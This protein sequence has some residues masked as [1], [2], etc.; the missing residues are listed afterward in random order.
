MIITCS[1][2]TTDVIITASRI[3][4]KHAYYS[5]TNWH[6]M[7]CTCEVH[8]LVFTSREWKWKRSNRT[9]RTIHFNK[10]SE[11]IVAMQNHQELKRVRQEI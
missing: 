9:Q 8:K 6:A 7:E 1:R 2:A 4:H 11:N 10:W 3:A 5:I